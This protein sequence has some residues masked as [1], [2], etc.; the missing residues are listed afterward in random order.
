MS[1]NT[2]LQ[3][4]IS[5]SLRDQAQAQVLE[6]G[7]SS[8]QDYIRLH[9]TQLKDSIIRLS[10]QPKTIKLGPKA[11]KRYNKIADDIN[12]GKNIYKTDSYEDFINQ[13]HA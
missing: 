5:K 12:S 3:I 11:I 2:V 9:L 1:N 13:L 8:L 7:F 4:P 6:A 10:Y